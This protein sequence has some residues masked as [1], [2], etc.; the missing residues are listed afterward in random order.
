MAI[1]IS[2][3]KDNKGIGVAFISS[4]G[5]PPEDRPEGTAD[6]AAARRQ[7]RLGALLIVPACILPLYFGCLLFN[8]GDGGV[9]LAV[10]MFLGVLLAMWGVVKVTLNKRMVKG[11]L[12]ITPLLGVE[13]AATLFLFFYIG[14]DIYATDHTPTI[15]IVDFL[16]ILT[17][18]LAVS[19]V[20]LVIRADGQ[21][22]KLEGG[23]S[24]PR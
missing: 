1:L 18:M 23:H 7:L 16:L 3:V 5:S 20:F 15:P 21:L 4:L 11:F 8:S 24:L 17:T 22:A 6:I 2:P 9:C 13:L 14:F 12:L 19:G 10:V